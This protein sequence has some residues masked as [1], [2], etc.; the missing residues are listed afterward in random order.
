MSQL[1][2]QA[3][4]FPLAREIVENCLKS[5]LPGDPLF[6]RAWRKTLAALEPS[7]RRGALGGV[8]GHVAES[9]VEVIFVD[10]GY[11]AVWHF[12]GPGRHGVDLLMLCPTTERLVAIEVKGTLRPNLW[13]RFRQG[14]LRQMS[15]DWL[16][17][18]DN[19]G[20]AEW[21]LG[22]ADVY[23][24][25]ALVNLAEMAYKVGFTSDF[26]ELRPVTDRDQLED[27]AWLDRR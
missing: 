10:A 9:V 18:A 23:G 4:A 11:H 21:G 5:H 2:E 6:K 15:L 24:A 19:P 13:P 8:T 22:G 12:V 27:L 3:T 16:D 17:K 1:F 14:E 7:E 26:A 20:M 25:A